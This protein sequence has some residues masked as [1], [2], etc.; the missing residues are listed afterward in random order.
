MQAAKLAVDFASKEYKSRLKVLVA[1]PG[2]GVT[3]ER[4]AHEILAAFLPRTFRHPVDEAD[5][6]PY[7]GLFQAAQ[8]RGR[9]FESS[10]FFAL[11]GALVSPRF[12]FHV[13]PPNDSAQPRP[14]D[15]YAL[16]SRLS[17]FL[18]GSMPDELLFDVAAAGKLQDPEVLR[19]LVRRMLRNDRSLIFAQRFVEQWLRTRELGAEKSPDAKLFPA[20]A[21]DEELRSDI[22]FQPILFFREIVLRNLTLL[23]L[24]D[25]KYTIGTSN[26]AKH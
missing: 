12:L 23:N 7:L 25:S 14:L 21:N 11:R 10:I 8:K 2:P 22:R 26:L 24:L 9:P 3:A 13:E 6:A 16:A 5:I 18:W 17:Y 19:E 15:Q 20:Y 4:A 1:K